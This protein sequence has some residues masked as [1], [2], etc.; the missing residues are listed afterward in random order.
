[1]KKDL[2]CGEIIL[3][4]PAHEYMEDI[5]KFRQEIIQANDDDAFAG[6][7]GLDNVDTREKLEEWLKLIEMMSMEETCPSDRVP[8]DVYIA[9]RLSDNKIVGIIDLRHHINHP[10]LGTWGGHIGYTVRPDERG[11]GYAVEMLGQ[12]LLNC[13]KL[14]LE[15]VM[16]TCHPNNIASERTILANGGVFEKEIEVDG[17]KVK[18]YW[19]EL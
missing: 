7:S 2:L 6:C 1:M 10:V 4:K 13:K 17:T 11:K 9:V 12:N 14:G 8:S 5:L 3:K 18:R 16:V 19:I 15:R